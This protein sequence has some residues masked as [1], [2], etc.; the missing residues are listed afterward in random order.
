MTSE[1]LKSFRRALGLSAEGYARLLRM[2]GV[3]AGRT[4]QRWESGEQGVPGY[5]TL[6]CELL[7]RVPAA[8]AF[9]GLRLGDR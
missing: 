7:E 2:Q 1:E 8:R 4:V 5:V 3:H 9:L 6:L